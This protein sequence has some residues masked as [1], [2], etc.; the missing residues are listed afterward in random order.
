M[1][2]PGG[3]GHPLTLIIAGQWVHAAY[4]QLAAHTYMILYLQ[5]ASGMRI[6]GSGTSRAEFFDQVHALVDGRTHP[7]AVAQAQHDLTLALTSEN[8]IR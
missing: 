5:G 2:R 8:T 1:R 6:V 4:Y 7:I 3:A